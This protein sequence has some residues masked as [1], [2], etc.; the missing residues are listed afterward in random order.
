MSFDQDPNEQAN[1][2][3]ADF[4]LMCDE[5]KRLKEENERL[6]AAPKLVGYVVKTS[7]ETRASWHIGKTPKHGENLY[8]L[9][10]T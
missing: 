1:V 2:S 7:Y 9:P 3:A 5:M 4:A 8:I 6:R 10:G